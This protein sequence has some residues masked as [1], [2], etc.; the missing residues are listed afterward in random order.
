MMR[1]GRTQLYECRTLERP[2]KERAG[3]TKQGPEERLHGRAPTC[4]HDPT[5]WGHQ[6]QGQPGAGAHNT[7]RGQTL[8]SPGPPG[9]DSG[10][11]EKRQ[12]TQ[13]QSRSNKPHSKQRAEF[14]PP[15]NFEHSVHKAPNV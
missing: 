10:T 11:M 8:N 6:K 15:A 12:Y 2:Q 14:E 7:Q 13:G 9:S 3:A 4:D 1:E 5:R